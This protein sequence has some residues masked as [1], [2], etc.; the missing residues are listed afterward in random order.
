MVCGVATI[1]QR[2]EVARIIRTAHRARNKMVHISVLAMAELPALTASKSIAPENKLAI[3]WRFPRPTCHL[4]PPDTARVVVPTPHLP[5][6]VKATVVSRC[7]A[8]RAG[9]LPRSHQLSLNQRL[10]IMHPWSGCHH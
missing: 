8:Q 7:R 1:A 10:A 5:V 9:F 3:G 4:L 2:D 6:C